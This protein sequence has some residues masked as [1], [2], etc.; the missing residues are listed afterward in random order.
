MAHA[1]AL[2]LLL[3]LSGAIARIQ[4][5]PSPVAD[6]PL[7]SSGDSSEARAR[8]L[9]RESWAPGESGRHLAQRFNTV[10]YLNPTSRFTFMLYVFAFVC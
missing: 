8:P 10:K 6:L 4:Q 7:A 9:K 3:S 1:I 5:R 2:V